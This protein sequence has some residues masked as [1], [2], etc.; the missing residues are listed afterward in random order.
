MD[1][2]SIYTFSDYYGLDV[3]SHQVKHCQGL[4]NTSYGIWSSKG[5]QPGNHVTL[6]VKKYKD[7]FLFDPHTCGIAMAQDSNQNHIA[8]AVYVKFQC[9]DGKQVLWITQL[10]VREDHRNKGVATRLLQSLWTKNDLWACGLV[11]CHP[12]AVKSLEAATSKKCNKD[13]SIQYANEFIQCSH[14][15]YVQNC[16][17]KFSL[18][19]CAIQTHFYV[20]HG[21]VDTI[22]SSLVD[23]QLGSLDAGE[24]Y[25]AFTFK[26]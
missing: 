18:T 15:P 23:W 13:L 25:F 21:M 20:E 19:K 2:L 16:E 4:Y 14:I 11:S 8:Q 24:E 10:V 3:T 5:P 6:S 22:R 7:Q 26:E 9:R 1:S 17:T 12:Y